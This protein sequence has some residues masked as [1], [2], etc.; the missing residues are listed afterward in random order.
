MKACFQAAGWTL[1]V[2]KVD[3]NTWG[4]GTVMDQ[5]PSEG[6]D[7]NAKDPGTIELSVSTGNPPQ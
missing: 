1:H 5:F 4:D 2:K 7:V 3:D 6:T